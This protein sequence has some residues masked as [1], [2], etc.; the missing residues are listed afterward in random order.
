[1]ANGHGREESPVEE[2]QGAQ[3]VPWVQDHWWVAGMAL[4]GK[5]S[6]APVGWVAAEEHAELEDECCRADRKDLV[7]EEEGRDRE[8]VPGDGSSQGL[9]EREEQA[10]VEAAEAEV[11]PTE[12]QPVHVSKQ[13]DRLA[14]ERLVAQE[15]C[16]GWAR[17]QTLDRSEEAGDEP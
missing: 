10:L 12:E 15:R 6:L 11:H 3:M 5:V 16:L 8:F 13:V 17:R 9:Q 1:M 2:G 7:A 14:G 4:A